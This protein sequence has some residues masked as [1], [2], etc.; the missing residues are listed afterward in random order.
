MVFQAP[1]VGVGGDDHGNHIKE[2]CYYVKFYDEN[3]MFLCAEPFTV[4][5]TNSDDALAKVDDLVEGHCEE[6]GY[7]Q[8]DIQL[9]DVC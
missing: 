4:P 5:E 8:A 3:G 7:F 2:F 9:E 1:N 6:F